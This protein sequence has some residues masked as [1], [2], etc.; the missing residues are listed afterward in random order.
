MDRKKCC[1]DNMPT[2][3]MPQHKA[4]YTSTQHQRNDCATAPLQQQQEQHYSS[5]NSYYAAIMQRLSR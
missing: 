5:K 4:S 2:A 3:A 1:R